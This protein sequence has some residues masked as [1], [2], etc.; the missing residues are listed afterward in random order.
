[1]GRDPRRSDPPARP[2]RPALV[3]LTVAVATIVAL[4]LTEGLFR[5]I[6]FPFDERSMV[7]G[8]PLARFDPELGWDYIPGRT[9]AVEFPDPE[10]GGAPRSIAVSLDRAFGARVASAQVRIDPAAP[11]IVFVGDSFTMGHG[12][13]WDE[14]FAGRVAAALPGVQV[15]NLAVQGYG[16]D[17]ALLRLRR[18]ASRFSDLRAVVY[19]FI[20]RHVYRNENS[21]RRL[22]LGTARFAGTTPRFALADDG[23]LVL[24]EKPLRREEA[25]VHSHVGAALDRAWVQYGPAPSLALTHALVAEM[26]REAEARGA[27]FF[28]LEWD[29][30]GE[31]SY[32]RDDG[33]SLFETTGIPTLRADAGAPP[34]FVTWVIPGDWHPTPRAHAH[35]AAVLVDA[36]RDL[37]PPRGASASPQS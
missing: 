19:G 15:V 30:A 29:A 31:E 27:R 5:L 11:S 13:T 12:V 7:S 6:G 20:P 14:S 33:G 21:D 25:R 23:S 35:V 9:T 36:L 1:M 26:R 3:V 2:G 8:N 18:Y 34:D 10:G 17:Q 32:W 4:A 24:A 28:I 37:V 16:T 22:L